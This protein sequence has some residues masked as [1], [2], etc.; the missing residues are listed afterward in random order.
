MGDTL[1]SGGVLDDI[2]DVDTQRARHQF[3]TLNIYQW[4]DTLT[5]TKGAHNIQTGANIRRIRSVD[6]RDD[7]VIGSITTPVANIGADGF[8]TVADSLKER[9]AFLQ[10]VDNTRF[11]HL[12]ISLLGIVSQTPALI[13]RDAS[14]R[15]QPLGTGLFTKSTL[16]AYEFYASDTWRWKPSLT[17]TYGLTY[18][19]QSPPIE[20]SGKQ[21]VIVERASGKLL[22]YADYIRNKRAAAERGEVF[23]P[24]LAYLPLKDAGRNTA[25]NTDYRD[26]SPRLSA[27]WN[28]SFRS[29][30]LGKVFGDRS[31]VARGGYS[32]VYDR[33]TTVQ[34]III[35]TLGV[36][37]AQTVNVSAPK[38]G[39]G[40][41]V[42]IGL[43]VY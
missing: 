37:F 36:G 34:T 16:G 6:F 41:P 31:T 7:K 40:T 15:L 42:R 38:N 26:F 10:A 29:G 21:T 22:G 13:T 14:L 35:P 11:D 43:D 39:A 5:W 19:W 1:T 2:I 24:E 30:L 9:P 8:V 17:V 27:A 18:N 3:R 4:A 33:T 25:Y 12:Y 32:L 23:N 20:D 28:P